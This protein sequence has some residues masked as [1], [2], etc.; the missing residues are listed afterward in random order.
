MYVSQVI[1]GTGAGTSM[2]VILI[3]YTISGQLSASDLDMAPIL[4]PVIGPSRGKGALR[5]FNSLH[6]A[7]TLMRIIAFT[8][9]HISLCGFCTGDTGH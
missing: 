8:L 6:S 5:A 2:V 3:V 7:Y 4:L 9:Q 1:V